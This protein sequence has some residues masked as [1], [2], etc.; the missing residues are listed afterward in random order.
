MKLELDTD[1]LATIEG[2]LAAAVERCRYDAANALKG[3]QSRRNAMAE[4]AA[5]ERMAQHYRERGERC[6]ALLDRIKT[7]DFGEGVVPS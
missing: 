1:E 2:A 3:A 5:Y 6:Q 7:P 4:R